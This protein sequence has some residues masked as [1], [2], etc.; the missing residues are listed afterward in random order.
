MVKTTKKVQWINCVCES[1]G[2]GKEVA[3]MIG[4]KCKCRIYPGRFGRGAVRDIP[5]EGVAILIESRLK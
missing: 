3:P 5:T 4:Y 2:A 1:V